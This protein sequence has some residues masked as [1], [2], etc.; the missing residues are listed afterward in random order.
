MQVDPSGRKWRLFAVTAVLVLL[1]ATYLA[2]NY[3]EQSG[4]VWLGLYTI[5][6]HMF[7]SPFP[8]EPVLLFYAKTHPALACAIASIPGLEINA[9]ATRMGANGRVVREPD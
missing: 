5:P 2:I 7:V 3:P 1:T 4:M 8:H 9:T 6:S